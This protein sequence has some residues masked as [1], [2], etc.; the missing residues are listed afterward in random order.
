M[1]TNIKNINNSRTLLGLLGLIPFIAF[2]ISNTLD[3]QI[4]GINSMFGFISYST[5]ILSFLAG[6]LWGRTLSLD[7]TKPTNLVIFISN[8]FSLTAWFAL[9]LYESIP[10]EL[11]ICILG[12]GFILVLISEHQYKKLLYGIKAHAYLKLRK[13]LSLIVIL[14]HLS[15]LLT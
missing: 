1:N 14:L 10:Q 11:I 13:I 5:I 3:T 12:I 9:L 4:F 6:S 2:T 7:G 8:L 15:M